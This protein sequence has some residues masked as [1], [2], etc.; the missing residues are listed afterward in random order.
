[1]R[2]LLNLPINERVL[3]SVRLYEELTEEIQHTDNRHARVTEDLAHGHRALPVRYHE[4]QQTRQREDVDEATNGA[5]VADDRAHVRHEHGEEHA[6]RHYYEVHHQHDAPAAL[7]GFEDGREQLDAQHV[8]DERI[9]G[10]E[11]EE[12]DEACAYGQAVVLLEVV[13]DILRET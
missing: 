13:Q 8:R 2:L 4:M 3:R 6:D 12:E 5:G 9:D 7:S 10:E 1:M 11:L